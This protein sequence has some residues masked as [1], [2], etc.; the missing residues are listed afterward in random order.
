MAQLVSELWPNSAIQVKWLW[1]NDYVKT[2][3]TPS[4]PLFYLFIWLL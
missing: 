1:N 3:P 4:D 2:Q